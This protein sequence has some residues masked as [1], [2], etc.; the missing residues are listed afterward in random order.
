MKKNRVNLVALVVALTVIVM[1]IIVVASGTETYATF[2]ALV[3]PIVA[4]GLALIT[5]EV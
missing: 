5:K 3:P 1:A 4:I 2:W